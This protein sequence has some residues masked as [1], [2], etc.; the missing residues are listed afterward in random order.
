MHVR[1]GIVLVFT[2]IAALGCTNDDDEA[3]PDPNRIFIP[4]DGDPTPPTAGLD[5]YGVP[6][7]TQPVTVT[8]AT[9][10][11][12][13][14][15]RRGSLLTL[16]GG[17]QDADGGVSSVMIRGETTARCAEIDGELGTQERA[18]WLKPWTSTAQPG[19]YGLKS[20]FVS[21]TVDLAEVTRCAEGWRFVSVRGV[22]TVTGANFHGGTATT[23]D[24]SFA[25]P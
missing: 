14:R 15:V 22:F 23:P 25:A 5:A 12:A 21:L 2:L 24:F 6:N 13:V 20:P 4:R 1:V 19:E 8:A 7:A 9:G 18:I 16:V 10:A 17:G 3:S 11:V